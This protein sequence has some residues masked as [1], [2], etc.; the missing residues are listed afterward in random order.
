M[1]ITRRKRLFIY[2][3]ISLLLVPVLA[4]CSGRSSGLSDAV[5]AP[6]FT[7]PDL[8]GK[9]ISLRDFRGKP[10][11]LVFWRVNCPSCEYQMPFLQAFYEKWSTDK[12]A[13]VTVNV[14]E[15]LAMVGEYVSAHGLTFPVLLDTRQQVSQTYGIIGVPFTFFIDDGGM[16]R[17]YRVGPFQD[18]EAIE[19]A[20][21]TAFPGL[22]M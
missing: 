21:K 19:K 20:V 4:G 6:D 15:P 18:R 17:A 16:F 14:G 11:I 3:I 9:T 7:L 1:N 22:E 12:I 2:L 13:L 5:E 10:V 8:E